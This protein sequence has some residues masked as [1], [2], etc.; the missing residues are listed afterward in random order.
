MNE[1]TLNRATIIGRL[2]HDP[3]IKQ[4]PAGKTTASFTV[5]TL[6]EWRDRSGNRCTKSFAHRVVVYEL[7]AAK[8][9]ARR[10][11]KG[12]RIL[13]EGE[14]QLRRWIN[15]ETGE[16][17]NFVTEIVLS[18]F[19]ARLAVLDDPQPEAVQ[20]E[21]PTEDDLDDSPT[22]LSI[23]RSAAKYGD[24]TDTIDAGLSFL[25]QQKG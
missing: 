8:F 9:A 1:T 2:A 23:K 18:G 5:V 15:R 6:S 21:A 20:S 24:D 16:A 25:A 22:P 12:S 14:L 13:L 19:N 7:E 10:L 11:R 17:E 4:T 3:T